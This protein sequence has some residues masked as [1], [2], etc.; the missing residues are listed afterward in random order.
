MINYTFVYLYPHYYQQSNG[1]NV[2]ATYQNNLNQSSLNYH[3]QNNKNNLISTNQNNYNQY[4]QWNFN[5]NNTNTSIR[6][7]PKNQIFNNPNNLNNNNQNYFNLNNSNPNNPNF[8]NQNSPHNLNPNNRCYYN[9]N[10]QSNFNSNNLY[11][12]NQNN[13]G[14]NN[15]KN[16]YYSQNNQNNQN[17]MTDYSKELYEVFGANQNNNNYPNVMNNQQNENQINNR[18]MINNNQ[19]NDALINKDLSR[20]IPEYYLLDDFNNN[21]KNIM[22][23]DNL[24]S[25]KCF[26][27]FFGL[28]QFFHYNVYKKYYNLNDFINYYD[29]IIIVYSEK[30]KIE[31]MKFLVPKIKNINENSLLNEIRKYSKLY[32][33]QIKK[34]LGIQDLSFDFRLK[35]VNLNDND[36]R[37]ANKKYELNIYQPSNNNVASITSTD[38]EFYFPLK[39]LRNVGSTCFMNAVL[40]C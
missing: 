32:E 21:I 1:Q 23:E 3:Y 28:N 6:N 22:K 12:Y 26:R 39:G 8:I 40:Q 33:Q 24:G 10:E 38:N 19:Q 15:Q 7:N 9:I 36:K 25:N 37:Y 31:Q 29:F 5:Q 14:Y 2:F 35:A 27:L 30:N 16:H 18:N 11:Y 13:Q 20:G 34:E 4:N 17:N